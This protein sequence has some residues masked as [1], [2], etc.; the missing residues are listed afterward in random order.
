M[1]KNKWNNESYKPGFMQM[2]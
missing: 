2:F 1:S